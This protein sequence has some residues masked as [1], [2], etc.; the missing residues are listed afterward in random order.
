MRSILSALLLAGAFLFS[1]TSHAAGVADSADSAEDYK[2][3]SLDDILN[4]EMTV[5]SG[6]TAKSLTQRESPAAVSV[7]TDDDIRKSGARDLVEV[8]KLIPGFD[9]QYGADNSGTVTPSLRGLKAGEGKMLLQVNGFNFV[10]LSYTNVQVFNRF[11]IDQVKKIEIIRGPGSALYGG[12]AELAVVNIILKD[13]SDFNGYQVDG[14][15]SQLQ[16]TTGREDIG[17]GYGYRIAGNDLAV[18]TYFGDAKLSDK[19]FTDEAGQTYRYDQ[20]TGYS[21]KFI[22]VNNTNGNLTTRFLYSQYTSKSTDNYY[23]PIPGPYDI[24]FTNLAASTSY[25]WKVNSKLTITPQFD[26]NRNGAWNVPE[27][28]VRSFGFWN[29]DTF[30]RSRGLV[31]GF[32]KIND[33]A[34]LLVG[35]ESS[36]YDTQFHDQTTNATTITPATDIN[37]QHLYFSTLGLFFQSTMK[38]GQVNLTLGARRETS[39]ANNEAAVV[40]R[41]GLTSVHDKFHVKA[42]W[43]QAFRNPSGTQYITSQIPNLKPELADTKELEF[44]Y[45][46]TPEMYL[47]LN[48]FDIL[49]HRPIRY[50]NL[51]YNNMQPFGSRG[52]ELEWKYVRPWGNAA[53][54]SSFYSAT[55]RGYAPQASTLDENAFM[56]IPRYKETLTGTYNINRDLF[57][58]PSLIYL[59]KV[60]SQVNNATTVEPEKELSWTLFNL[61]LL[62][63]NSFGVKN[64]DVGVGLYNVFDQDN[65]YANTNSSGQ[66][67]PLP[68]PGREYGAKVSYKF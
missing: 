24:R 33:W 1:V 13:G 17:L 68:G 4:I 32:Y 35:L 2:K 31:T 23:G 11:P 21:T 58:S 34:D 60:Y 6:S 36:H 37:N 41:I 8:L 52:A 43:G 48:L 42:L 51:G 5:A 46:I 39:T 7:I 63:A 26:Y 27:E 15:Y 65:Y 55:A 59:G 44:G 30:Q 14:I 53:F 16:H 9:V 29:E 40:P 64:M 45:K 49:I 57:L 62:H 3:I 18:N 66:P 38:F 54:T 50:D 12:N 20:N 67:P 47:T 22:N 56:G 61:Y 28:W 19:N 25:D 10:D